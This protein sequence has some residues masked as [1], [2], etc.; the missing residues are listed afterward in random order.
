[1]KEGSPSDNFF[2]ILEGRV[3]IET[4]QPG[5]KAM[6]LQHLHSGDIVGWSWL[7][8]P[9]EWVFDAKATTEVRTLAFDGRLLREKCA[10]NPAFGYELIKR[11]SQIMTV[12]LNIARLQS[13]G[14]VP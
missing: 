5:R 9:Y 4:N 14:T 6:A 10:E 13:L 8:P 7:F 12:R 2:A 11:F 1:G 3:A